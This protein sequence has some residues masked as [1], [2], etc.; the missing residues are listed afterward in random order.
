MTINLLFV[1]IALSI[2]LVGMIF[3][4]ENSMVVAK[5]PQT[6]S[7]KY[8]ARIS[9]DY[10]MKGRFRVT[11]GGWAFLKDFSGPV[12]IHVYAIGDSTSSRFRMNRFPRK[13]VTEFFKLPGDFHLHGF[14]ASALRL[15]GPYLNGVAV[16]LQD[17]EGNYYN[18]GRYD[19]K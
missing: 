16:V 9:L 17:N 3:I 7:T 1:P 12:K 8:E 6:F 5:I 2:L 15:F 13:D 11:V 19:C 4:E 10:C 18:G 14:T